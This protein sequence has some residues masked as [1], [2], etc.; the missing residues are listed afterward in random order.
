MGWQHEFSWRYF[1]L[2]ECFT[3]T[4]VHLNVLM[5][6]KCSYLTV[7]GEFNGVWTCRHCK[8]I[9]FLS[10]FTYF[11]VSAFPLANHKTRR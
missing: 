9:S 2:D 6:L 4:H 1:F 7:V 8:D 5:E 3:S 11:T 10:A